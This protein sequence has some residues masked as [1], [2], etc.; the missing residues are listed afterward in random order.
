M[1]NGNNN[2]YRQI[3]ANRTA[4]RRNE[5]ERADTKK[6]YSHYVSL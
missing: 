6:I 4:N 5:R 3:P 1:F 2:N